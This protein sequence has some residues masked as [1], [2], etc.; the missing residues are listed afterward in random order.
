MKKF[1]L[2]AALVFG[3]MSFT[4]VDAEAKRM[5]GGSSSGK[6]S[7]N[8]SRQAAPANPAQAKPAAAA[9]NAATPPKP[10]S[11]WKGIVGGL[12]GGALLGALFS[13]LGLGGALSSML[14]S[15]LTFALIGGAIFLLVRM[16]KNRR[17]AQQ[18]AFAYAGNSS[19]NTGNA[20]NANSGYNNQFNQVPAQAEPMAYN[21]NTGNNGSNSNNGNSNQFGSATAAPV[22]PLA[23]V[24][25]VAENQGNW[26]IPADFDVPNFLR[27]AK[28]NF[29]RL[30]AAWDKAD[31]NDI[32]EFTGPE[33][34]AELKMQLQERGASK[35]ETDV[36]TIDAEMLGVETQAYDYLA[37]VKFT[38][39]IKEEANMP[40]A[41]FSEVWNLAK[42]INGQGGWILVGI[43][44]A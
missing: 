1:I 25:A 26:T 33:M 23:G 14:G 38:G 12:I 20:N 22:A 40:A 5:G 6:Q 42:P 13:S 7:N 16:F 11:P 24:A 15:I 18:P 2:L 39:M 43:Q 31:V 44:Q 41:P 29:I 21:G 35:N 36:V 34:F 37:S 3:A 32:R 8:V 27:H 19:N 9:P 28:M 17:Q 4:V 10:A 30:Q